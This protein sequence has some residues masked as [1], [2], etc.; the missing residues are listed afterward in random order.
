[1]T[2]TKPYAPFRPFGTLT[3]NYDEDDWLYYVQCD[4]G[5]GEPRFQCSAE[6]DEIATLFCPGCKRRFRMIFAELPGTTD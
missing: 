2:A 3:L 6:E 4:C 5:T 1:M